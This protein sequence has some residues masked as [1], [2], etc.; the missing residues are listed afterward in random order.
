MTDTPTPTPN[1]PEGDPERRSAQELAQA[2][3]LPQLA[4]ALRSRMETMAAQIVHQVQEAVPEYASPVGAPR[5]QVL[6][7]AAQTAA[8]QFLDD[9]E[10][11]PGQ[12][13][14]VDEMF[15]RL[16]YT[17]AQ[18]GYSLES[19]DATLRAATR[20]SWHYLAEFAVEQNLSSAELRELAEA[21]FDYLEHL[22][23]Q[24][25]DGFNLERR[26][27]RQE[28]DTAR[29]R[30]FELFLADPAPRPGPGVSLGVDN[31]VLHALADAADWP[32]PDEIVALAVNYYGDPPDVP[33]SAGLL[34]HV[35]PRRVLVVCPPG[36][37]AELANRI[38]R[39]AP[40]LR[41]AVS[42]PVPPAESGSALRWCQRAL[43]LVQLGIIAPTPVVS[44]AEHATQLWLHAEPS[45]RQHLCQE[46]LRPLLAETPNSRSILSETL[47]TWV[48]T[49]ESAPA[50]AARLDVHPQTVRYRWKRI[51]ELF[52]QSLRDPE[53]VVQMTLVLKSSVPLWKAG[54][55]S[56]FDLFHDRAE[57]AS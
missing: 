22:R 1:S 29:V 16:G 4:H 46:L 7:M 2:S 52:G 25:A 31:D 47:L 35:E 10:H 36:E 12:A 24:L 28:R 18:R 51:N 44:C 19:L 48:E 57:S 6:T 53:F 43:D 8:R 26:V 14:H 3:T 41:I 27:G 15:R 5:H 38:G 34:L 49:R 17:Q 9:A 30:L 45:M 32:V 39:S 55:Q 56:D 33:G 21:V 13:R 11:L 42:W 23:Q 54:D 50:I 40:G 20:W 37:Q